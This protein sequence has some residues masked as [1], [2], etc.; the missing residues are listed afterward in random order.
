M[1]S[2]LEEWELRILINQGNPQPEPNK[3][4]N[5]SKSRIIRWVMD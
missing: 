4:F 5:Q 1:I 2:V 3:S